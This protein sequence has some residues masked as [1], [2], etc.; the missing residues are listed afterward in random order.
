MLVNRSES[1]KSEKKKEKPPKNQQ[2]FLSLGKRSGE[3][4]MPRSV[5]VQ[6]ETAAMFSVD[7]ATVQGGLVTQVPPAGAFFTG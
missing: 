2:K 1:V 5:A 7:T 6:N 4:T 3:G